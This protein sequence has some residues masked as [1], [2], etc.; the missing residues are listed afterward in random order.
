MSHHHQGDHDFLYFTMHTNILHVF[1]VPNCRFQVE[2][3]IKGRGK[4]A[5]KELRAS[6]NISSY[7]FYHGGRMCGTDVTANR[8]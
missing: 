6:S 2:I 1:F 4:P 3:A 5:V 7:S 8:G